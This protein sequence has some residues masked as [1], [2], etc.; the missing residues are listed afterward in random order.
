[1]GQK[2]LLGYDVG[3]SSIKA[4]LINAD[5]GKLIDSAISPEK[6]MK[7]HSPQSGWAEQHPDEWWRHVVT[8]TKKIF[9]GNKVKVKSPEIIGIG[10]SYQ[11]HGLVVVDKD[12]QVLRPSIIWCDSRA[13]ETG[14]KAFK[15]LGES[16]CLGNF[17]NSPGNFTGSKLKWVKE[18]EPDVYS[19]IYKIM[20]PGDFIAMKM[21]DKISTTISGL[22]EGIFWNFKE[23]NTAHD[24]INYFQLDENLIP[25]TVPTFSIQGNLTPS[26]A[27]QLGLKSGIPI[28]YRAGDQ[29]N[30][31]LSLNVLNPG[32]IATTA[33]TSGV[34]YGII[35]KNVYDKDSR[36]N[37]FAHVNY[38][39][40]QPNVGVLLCISGTGILYSWIKQ[41]LMD[42]KYSYNDLNDLAS[43]A[44][45]GS[46]GLLCYPFGNGAERVFNNREIQAHFSGINFNR[47]TKNDFLRAAQEGIVF[48]FKY[49]LEI[50]K[51]MGMKFDVIR[52]GH[53]NLFQSPVFREA[54]VNTC[55]V[56]LEIYNT[57]G[58]QGAARGAGIGAGFYS[59]NADA[60]KGLKVINKL[61]PDDQR[62]K[63]YNTAYQNWEKNLQKILADS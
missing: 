51:N 29:P 46:Q 41:N 56:K 43:K 48:S 11:M 23:K 7:I 42:S 54:F 34:I 5:T 9:K 12:C 52:A 33:G 58:S 21:T 40:K 44:P 18:N 14:N 25:D 55:N 22:S 57:H 39:E 60:F 1:M 35:D 19:K 16:Y 59:S 30:N 27:K 26:A 15:D 62:V 50:M 6:E 47:H 63:K 53:S 61:N 24:L 20:L 28:T 32:E 36:V 4:S 17:L 13:V 31:A 10:I 37:P 45:I 49:G 38:S 2:F 8:A 3:S